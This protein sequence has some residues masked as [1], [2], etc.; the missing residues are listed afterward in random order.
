MIQIRSFMRVD[1]LPN[2]IEALLAGRLMEEFE[3]L[4]DGKATADCVWL[5][6]KFLARELPWPK[7]VKKTRL[8]SNENFL[9]TYSFQSVEADRERALPRD[10]GEPL[11]D[12]YNRTLVFF[13]GEATDEEFSSTAHGAVS[14]GWRAARQLIELS[15]KPCA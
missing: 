1:G 3:E 2:V 8:L 13:A 11:R 14:S 7:A 5:L 6:E 4:D 10:L 9:G 12:K 15:G